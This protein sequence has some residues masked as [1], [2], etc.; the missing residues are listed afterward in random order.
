MNEK[1]T[2]LIKILTRRNVHIHQHICNILRVAKR[3]GIFYTPEEYQKL[4]NLEKQHFSTLNFHEEMLYLYELSQNNFT[5]N[6]TNFT[7]FKKR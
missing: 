6:F 3:G 4:S 5:F 7:N 1:T 2:T